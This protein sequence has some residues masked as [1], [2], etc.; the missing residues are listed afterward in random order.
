[1]GNA[2]DVLRNRPTDTERKREFYRLGCFVV[3]AGF[4]MAV[5]I[6]ADA[7]LLRYPRVHGIVDLHPGG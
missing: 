2:K 1:M 4:V 3:M 6:G 7:K 5:S